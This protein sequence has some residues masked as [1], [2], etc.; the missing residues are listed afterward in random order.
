MIRVVLSRI[1]LVKRIAAAVAAG[2]A[3]TAFAGCGGS[4]SSH[5]AARPSGP[6]AAKARPKAPA[7]RHPIQSPA[8]RTGS[9]Q[10][11]GTTRLAYAA[12]VR[13]H[14]VAYR[15][16]GRRPFASFGRLNVNGA[17]TVFAVRGQI[18]RR[19]CSAAWYRVQL[20][21]RPNGSIGYV[22]ASAVELS[23]VRARIVVDL[24]ARRLTLYRNGRPI[25]QAVAGVG[26]PA[27]PTPTGR[28]YVDQRLIPSDPSGPWGPG[29]I[30]ISAHSDVLQYSWIQGAPIAIHGTNEPDS[31]GR[32]VSHGCIR[33]DNTMLRRLFWRTPAGTPVIIRA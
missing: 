29:A 10:R 2:F 9:Q 24:S 26:A 5:N 8:C 18:V 22:D 25:V 20:P 31:V 12:I 30:G 15:S 27:T 19:D 28:F 17:R 7:A 16:P 23:A 3:L 21:I 4:G 14:A 11:V 6:P 33:L 13:R 1:W 32:A